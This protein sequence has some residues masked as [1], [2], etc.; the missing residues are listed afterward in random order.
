MHTRVEETSYEM[1]KKLSHWRSDHYLAAGCRSSLGKRTPHRRKCGQGDHSARDPGSH[2]MQRKQTP[3]RLQG[4]PRRLRRQ[5]TMY[6]TRPLKSTPPRP[7][8]QS[9]QITP[10]R[11]SSG[12]SGTPNRTISARALRRGHCARARSRSRRSLYGARP[13]PSGTGQPRVRCQRSHPRHP[14]SSAVFDAYG[15]GA[16]HTNLG[17]YAEALADFNRALNSIRATRT[18][19]SIEPSCISSYWARKAT[20]YRTTTR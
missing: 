4:R 15:L 12:Q 2:A 19:T 10:M 1:G 20:P 5:R 8:S 18:P 17:N 9:N 7:P 11:T 13:H 6:L 16:S 14:D 3:P